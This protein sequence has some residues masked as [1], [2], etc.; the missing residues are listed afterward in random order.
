[1]Q[2]IVVLD[3]FA[4]N[5]GDL[6]WEPLEK[7]G[8]LIRYDRTAPHETLL[9]CE[10]AFAILTNKVVIGKELINQLA[11]TLRYIGVTA[12]GYNVVDTAAAKEAGVCVTNIPAYSTH[13][14]AQMVFAH[15]LAMCNHVEHYS[16]QVCNEDKWTTSQDFCFTDLPLK[17]LCGHTMGI[18]GLGAIGMAVAHIAHA[19]GMNVVAFTSK[20]QAALPPFITACTMAALCQQSDVV[21]LHCPLTPETRHMVSGPW[22]AGMKKGS[23]LINT[24]RGPLVDE[25]AVAEALS[26][27]HLGAYCADV[28]SQEPPS[29]GNPLLG[30][31]RVQ[32]T[33]HIAWATQEARQRLMNCC[34]DNLAAF[35]QGKPINIVNK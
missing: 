28:L 11:P 16:H 3:G 6:S 15:L 22:L 34:A 29:A 19:F 7:L 27:G 35:I 13:A 17:E 26:S 30:A 20:P 10:G 33:P 32:L 9:R 14:V 18:V 23:I 5:P 4:M 12:T 21:T 8:T 24:G 2:R 25:E 31:P 1:M